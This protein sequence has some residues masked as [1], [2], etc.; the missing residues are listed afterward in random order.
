MAVVIRMKRGG[1]RNRPHYRITVADSR[2]PRDGRI[3]ENLGF[4]DP[5]ATREE[6]QLS[7]DLERAKYWVSKG[8]QPSETVHSILKRNGVYEGQ[9]PPKPRKRP[10]RKKATK[11]RVARR[12]AGRV[13]DQRRKKPAK[14]TKQRARERAAA[15][16]AA[17]AATES[18]E[19]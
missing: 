4:Y 2:F 6:L 15:A 10:G 3:I 8:A 11:T 14:V 7:L 19:S 17:P 5:I 13:R 9:E 12:A 18:S 1:R 16:A